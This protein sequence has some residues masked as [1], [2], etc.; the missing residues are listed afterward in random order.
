MKT[1]TSLLVNR[2]L[3]LA[4][5]LTFI[6]FAGKANAFTEYSNYNNPGIEYASLVA[7]ATENGVFINWVTVSE[8]NNSH[9]EV[10]RSTDMKS[11]KTVAMVLDGFST[12]GTNGKTYKFKE[13]AGEVRKG[14]T[15]YYR[16]KQIDTNNQVHYSSVMAVQMNATVTVFP[17]QETSISK[18]YTNNLTLLSKQSTSS[19]GEIKIP[20][21]GST[22][23]ILTACEIIM[24]IGLYSPKLSMA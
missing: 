7:N 24:G 3:T 5:T 20:V 2:L 22:A 13:A 10:E 18:V 23:G 9:F 1:F 17:K 8:Q 16:L 19:M 11:F 4:F 21:A 14:K 12:T 6:F 15:V